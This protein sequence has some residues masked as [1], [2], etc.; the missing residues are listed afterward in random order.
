MTARQWH[1]VRVSTARPP[2]SPEIPGFGTRF[3]TSC[4]NIHRLD[5]NRFEPRELT[6]AKPWLMARVRNKYARRRAPKK[7]EASLDDVGEAGLPA[8]FSRSSGSFSVPPKLRITAVKASESA[9]RTVVS[10]SGSMLDRE[11][12]VLIGRLDGI[13][14]EGDAEPDR[15]DDARRERPRAPCT[16]RPSRLKND[17]FGEPLRHGRL[18]GAFKV[19]LGFRDLASEAGAAGADLMMRLRIA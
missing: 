1:K 17:P 10:D 13:R 11:P 6:R 3:G 5:S 7:I 16:V 18:K 4:P 8:R 14:D 9:L 12:R 2:L 19:A 15:E